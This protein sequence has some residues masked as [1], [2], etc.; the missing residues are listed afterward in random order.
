M[1]LFV[2]GT[3]KKG[4]VRHNLLK[5]AKYIGKFLL[6]EHR[7]LKARYPV[8]EYT[9]LHSDMVAGELYEI[10]NKTKKKLDAIEQGYKLTPIEDEGVYLYRPISRFVG[11]TPIRKTNGAYDYTPEIHKEMEDIY[12]VG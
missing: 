9:G 2:Y 12:G 1:K 5:K 6:N 7:I 8:I 10:S 4:H 3:L 11:F